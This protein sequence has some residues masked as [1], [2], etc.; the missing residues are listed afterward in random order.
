VHHIISDISLKLESLDYISVA[1]SLGI[2]ST[3]FAQC[4]SDATDFA[5]IMQT[6][7]HCAI[8]SHSRSPIL[9]PVESSYAT[10]Y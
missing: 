1:E 8:Q 6:N 3:T 7:G 2:S 4:A 10:S 5:E 9:V